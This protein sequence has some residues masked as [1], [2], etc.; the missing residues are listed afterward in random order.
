MTWSIL[1]KNKSNS[2]IDHRKA[3]IKISI[4][5]QL[6]F[7]KI[8]VLFT[9]ESKYNVKFGSDQKHFLFKSIWFVI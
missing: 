6:L 1:E 8:D 9:D 3:F 7:V 5:Q 4:Y 2:K